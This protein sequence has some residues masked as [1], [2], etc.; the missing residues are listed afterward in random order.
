MFISEDK[1]FDS[2]VD[3]INDLYGIRCT[4]LEKITNIQPEEENN[5]KKTKGGRKKKEE[6]DPLKI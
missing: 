3:Y 2:A 1:G 6:F 4:R 5:T